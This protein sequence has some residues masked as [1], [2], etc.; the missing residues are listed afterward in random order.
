M[1][2]S[3]Q[4]LLGI[5]ASVLVVSVSLW[6]SV[7]LSP[8]VVLTW[9]SLILVAMVP[10]QMVIGLAWHSQ[11]PTFIAALPQPLRGLA[12]TALMS[13]VGGV[14]AFI[15]NATVG[16]GISPPTPFVNM[17]MIFAVPM[18]ISLIIVFQCWPFAAIFKDKPVVVGFALVIAAYVLAWLIFQWLFNFAFLE[19][20]P[21]Y[22]AALDPKGL[23][24]AWFP[25]AAG[26]GC[27][28]G[29]L[30]LVLLDFWPVKLVV[31][32]VPALARQP[33]F[34][35]LAMLFVAAIA[36]G[37]WWFFDVPH[38]MD[39]VS[40][41]VQVNVAMVFGIFIVLVMFE[42]APFIRMP[43]P[44]RGLV[45]IAV[46]A[47]LAVGLHALYRTIAVQ[48]FGLPHGAPTYALELWLATSMLAITFPLMVA[49]ASFFN[50][51]PL[52]LSEEVLERH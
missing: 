47:A 41:L 22:R 16:G 33:W 42:G 31:N 2:L 34:G 9:I 30:C 35:L 24:I 29:V 6:I 11:Q 51:W 36:K 3:S 5:I 1:K 17:F 8:D 13:L 48:K 37:L 23:F 32:T 45:L 39:V 21:F 14:V 15:A 40:F 18:T 20:A 12:F 50:F 27:V 7:T 10:M 4:P 46:A 43:Q 52:R 49:F 25:L 44:L 26:L 28:V 19:H 38:G